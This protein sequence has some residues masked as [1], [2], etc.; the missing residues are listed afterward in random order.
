MI[1]KLYYHPGA[2]GSP[3]RF[4]SLRAK[5]HRALG[6]VTPAKSTP[7]SSRGLGSPSLRGQAPIDSRMTLYL[8]RKTSVSLASGVGSEGLAPIEESCRLEQVSM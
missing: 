7:M 5:D 2:T 3:T 8:L 1:G 4:P 6:V